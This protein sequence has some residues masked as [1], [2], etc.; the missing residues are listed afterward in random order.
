[1]YDPQAVSDACDLLFVSPEAAHHPIRESDTISEGEDQAELLA[2]LVPTTVK[3]G[4]ID[5]IVE[6]L[7][8]VAFIESATWTV[9]TSA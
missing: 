8:R 3:P 7:R 6:Q 9:G 5:S 4:E 2:T 1:M